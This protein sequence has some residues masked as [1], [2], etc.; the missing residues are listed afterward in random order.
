[1]YLF[2]TY[3]SH[4]TV[5]LSRFT[6]NSS[7]SLA[8]S[9]PIK[10]PTRHREQEKLLRACNTQIHG[11]LNM[12][13]LFPYLVQEGKIAQIKGHVVIQTSPW[14]LQY[15]VVLPT[16]PHPVHCTAEFVTSH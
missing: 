8:V 11:L 7:S 12:E 4:I 15:L 3:D 10:L 14:L 5:L 2:K 13:V 6:E 1:M 16:V 9:R